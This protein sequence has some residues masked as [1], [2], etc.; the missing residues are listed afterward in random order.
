MLEHTVYIGLGANLGQAYATLKAASEDLSQLP[1]V[2]GACSSAFYR[3]RPHDGRNE[4]D[5]CN[6]VIA[7]QYIG[8]AMQLLADL[9]QI[10]NKYG[11]ERTADKWAART[12]DLD[13]LLFGDEVIN[14]DD[15]TLPHY[16]MHNRDFVL[17]PL[18]EIAPFVDIPGHGNVQ[19]LAK[20]LGS[21]LQV[22]LPDHLEKAQ[23]NGHH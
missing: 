22:W 18:M 14:T 21:K 19:Q 13:I 6:A 20:Q 4:P 12:L 10:E 11:R 1:G 8:T 23:Q 2:V 3:S 5:Y 17:I 16:D 9:Q 15:L 7:L